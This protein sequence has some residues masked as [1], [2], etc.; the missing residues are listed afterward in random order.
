MKPPYSS[1]LSNS[2]GCFV[3]ILKKPEE[4]SGHRQD[5]SRLPGIWLFSIQDKRYPHTWFP[6][7]GL[8]FDG[9]CAHRLFLY[10]SYYYGMLIGILT[11]TKMTVNESSPLF[12][13]INRQ[14]YHS[15]AG[16]TKIFIFESVLCRILSGKDA[17]RTFLLFPLI[18]PSSALQAL[19]SAHGACSPLPRKS[20]LHAFQRSPR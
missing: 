15:P 2:P 9:L 18:H 11:Q 1:C 3:T 13:K 5:F 10:I 20:H 19:P 8:L 4:Q 16:N 14:S 12:S 17:Y 6:V 7:K